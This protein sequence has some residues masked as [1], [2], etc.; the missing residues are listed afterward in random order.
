MSFTLLDTKEEIALVSLLKCASD[1]EAS[2]ELMRQKLCE[3]NLFEPYQA[4]KSLQGDSL[5]CQLNLDDLSKW[6]GE[7]PFKTVF[8]TD[9]ELA[10]A[11]HP[12]VAEEDIA[13]RYEGF[14]KMVL[15]R[16]NP[17]LRSLAMTRHEHGLKDI[18]RD[19]GYN[20]IRLLE[21]EGKVHTVLMKRKRRLM[22][23]AANSAL[24][25]D[26]IFR[27]FRWLQSESSVPGMTHISPLA[28]R[29]LLHDTIGAFTL[30]QVESLF[31]RVNVSGSGM[32]SY[33]EWENFLNTKH[34]DEFLS[35]VFLTQF[36]T[37]CPVCGV[38]VQRD[39]GAC[40]QVTCSYCR[41]SFSCVT[42]ADGSIFDDCFL[43][44]T[45]PLREAWAEGPSASPRETESPLFRKSYPSGE[46][47][48]ND[49]FT[50]SPSVRR[51][52][53]PNSPSMSTR[54]SQQPFVITHYDEGRPRT[55]VRGDHS[56]ARQSQRS[57]PPLL[58]SGLR[59]SRGAVASPSPF[60]SSYA[61]T[62]DSMSSP[63]SPSPSRFTLRS[64]VS[65]TATPRDVHRGSLS[66]KFKDYK[67]G[68]T[69]M[70]DEPQARTSVTDRML[71]RPSKGSEFLPVVLNVMTKQIDLDDA[72]NEEKRVLQRL[73]L[74]VEAAY[75]LLDRYKKGYISDTDIWQLLHDEGTPG[76]VSFSAVCALFREHKP[77]NS[78]SS[79]S[80]ESRKKEVKNLGKLTLAE[81][82]HLLCPVESD[83]V[84]Y[85]SRDMGDDEARNVLYMLRTTTPC[86]KCGIR[87]QRT[88]EGCPSVTCA[89][90]FTSFRCTKVEDN[91]GIS[92]HS[93]HEGK[94]YHVSRSLR[95]SIQKALKNMIDL[96]E[97]SERLRKS[98]SI[99]AGTDTVRTMI[100]D[101]FLHLS[102][103]KGFFD[104]VDVKRK[105]S[106]YGLYRSDKE[107]DTLER[108]YSQ[109]KSRISFPDFAEQL[110]PHSAQP[111][112]AY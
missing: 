108:R 72:I 91:T 74:N 21:E 22:D 77:K 39:G 90:C 83:E 10:Q 63:R 5:K 105:M 96:C 93:W 7:Q 17:M 12:F 94:K 11:L 97:E 38:H 25:Q 66:P 43:R 36:T 88:I 14:L 65:T 70:F 2:V 112:L 75:S 15:P 44:R 95:F 4:F 80:T 41:A 27:A 107:L 56:P 104:V 68:V 78:G 51:S 106:E 33:N 81:L 87:T 45:T 32:L 13:L 89:L 23:I 1:G 57:A 54:T 102:S 35:S 9:E 84:N 71:C 40:S 50:R 64:S 53:P 86:P 19:V 67:G 34:V 98:L 110:R 73:E 31:R 52:L 6:L 58:P 24:R 82:V 46:S 47:P 101:S 20:L 103:E 111:V 42:N 18:G 55:S 48:R 76:T 60:R 8:V 16:D 100:M 61:E 85:I 69:D 59:S 28:L 49:R 79:A 92:L 29:R 26:I 99:S 3:C 30:E 37:Q 109:G 62:E